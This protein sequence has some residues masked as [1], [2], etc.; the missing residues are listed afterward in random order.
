MVGKKQVRWGGV[1]SEEELMQPPVPG[2]RPFLAMG[3]GGRKFR[4]TPS[5]QF[6]SVST[7][8]SGCQA[9]GQ[10]LWVPHFHA[11]PTA[12]TLHK[13]VMALCHLGNQ[14]PHRCEHGDLGPWTG[15][16]G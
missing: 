1:G 11:A 3:G 7:W 15:P 6:L 9:N 10:L 8:E 16:G 14:W 2:V 13:L 4:A 5:S 12:C